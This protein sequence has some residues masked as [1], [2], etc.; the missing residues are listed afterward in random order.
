MVKKIAI[1][2][3]SFDPVTRGHI[4]IIRRAAAV[5]DEVIAAVMVNAEKPSGMF[6]ADERLEILRCAVRD[7]DNADARL[8]SGLA[9]DFAKQ[10]GA[11]Y[12]V[13]GVRS[14]TD[15]DYEYSLAS[16]M[17]KFDENIE[18]FLI[19]SEPSLAHISSSYARER[20]RYGCSLED[21]ADSETAEL[22]LKLYNKK[23]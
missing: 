16:I 17:K 11:R 7:I 2:P 6:T 19:P 12:F 20:I 9:S 3:G 1:V 8:C 18:T 14:G 5:F 23:K 15:F 10:H 22:I 13:K 21:I 4:D